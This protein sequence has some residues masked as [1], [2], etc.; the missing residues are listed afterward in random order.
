[1]AHLMLRSQAEGQAGEGGAVIKFDAS[2]KT[3]GKSRSRCQTCHGFPTMNLM[4]PYHVIEQI[5]I[6]L[7]HLHAHKQLIS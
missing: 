5:L 7:C 4:K 3:N 1:M 2:S 6:S